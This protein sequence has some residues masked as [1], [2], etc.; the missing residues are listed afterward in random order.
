MKHKRI[1]DG[2]ICAGIRLL[3]LAAMAAFLLPAIQAGTEDGSFCP[4]CPDWTNLDGWMRQKEAQSQSEMQKMSGTQGAIS[5]QKITVQGDQRS[6][7]DYDLHWLLTDPANASGRLIDARSAQDFASG[8][9]AGAC[10]IYWQSVR[11]GGRLNQTALVQALRDAGISTDQPVVVYGH[12]DDASYLFWALQYLGSQHVSRLDGGWQAWKDAGMPVT[13]AVEEWQPSGYVPIPNPHLSATASMIGETGL[14]A[15]DARSSFAD[16]GRAHLPRAIQIPA[17]KILDD[18]MLRSPAELKELFFGR[19][20]EKDK[21][22]LVYGMPEAATLYYALRLAGYNA[23]L[24]DGDWW[25]DHSVSNI[26]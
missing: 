7:P 9:A 17:E 18:G 11:S 25:S 1:G 10:N 21:T 23:T 16:F 26:R 3:L 2:L 24:L 8:H 4:T 13:T 12:G 6:A 14:L 22:V 19:G 5:N 20:L 15:I